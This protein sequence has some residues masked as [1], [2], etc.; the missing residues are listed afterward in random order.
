M[1]ED[2]WIAIKD[3]KP[4][5]QTAVW[6]HHA[7]GRIETAWHEESFREEGDQ[8]ITHWR[9]LTKPEPPELPTHYPFSAITWIAGAK[10]ADYEPMTVPL[11]PPAPAVGKRDEAIREV[12]GFALEAMHAQ[13]PMSRVIEDGKSD[14]AGMVASALL[15]RINKI[16]A[17]HEHDP[18]SEPKLPFTP[19]HFSAMLWETNSGSIDKD[20]NVVFRVNRSKI[21]DR[22]EGQ[23]ILIEI[24]EEEPGPEHECHEES[25]PGDEQPLISCPTCE[26][27]VR[28]SISR[29]R[30]GAAFPLPGVVSCRKCGCNIKALFDLRLG[31]EGVK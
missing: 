10:D 17:E 31:Q 3:E 18:E 19:K 21:P 16:L 24:V 4:P 6:V 7:G 28:A 27:I 29:H 2:G 20:G 8:D 14:H 15:S 23:E 30:W 5:D 9:P 12:I 13:D 26:G 11:K 22:F 1:T 25:R